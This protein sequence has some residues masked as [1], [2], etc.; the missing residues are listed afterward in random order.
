[1]RRDRRGQR[2]GFQRLDE[3]TVHP[4]R[5]AFLAVFFE[6]VRRQCNDRRSS[7][8]TGFS[9]SNGGCRRQTVD[10]RHAHVHQDDVK[11]FALNPIDR[12]LPIRC[13]DDVVSCLRQ[14]NFR[15]PLI[16]AIVF[17]D[18][19]PQ[20]SLRSGRLRVMPFRTG[21]PQQSAAIGRQPPRDRMGMV[22]S[23]DAS[24]PPGRD[25]GTAPSLARNGR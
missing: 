11:L 21:P 25:P 22:N 10:V 16:D 9:P 4:G 14:D 24:R 6:R 1:M 8:R 19:N 18:E 12:L 3:K 5:L 13:Q 20:T 7:A 17:R 23:D 15:Q 2:L